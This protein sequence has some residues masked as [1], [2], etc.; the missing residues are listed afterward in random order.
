M[1]PFRRGVEPDPEATREAYLA[2]HKDRIRT[3]REE[4]KISLRYAPSAADQP[5][6]RPESVTPSKGKGVSGVE[7]GLQRSGRVASHLSSEQPTR[8]RCRIREGRS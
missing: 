6:D 3:A 4:V 8:L 7:P 1:N 5:V 2:R